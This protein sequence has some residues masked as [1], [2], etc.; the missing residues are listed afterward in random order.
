MDNKKITTAEI[1][2]TAITIIS[3]RIKSEERQYDNFVADIVTE[4][5]STRSVIMNADSIKMNVDKMER[6]SDSITRNRQFLGM[7]KEIRD[8]IIKEEEK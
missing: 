6:C 3:S 4:S 1:V 2:D 7:L 8:S 5:G